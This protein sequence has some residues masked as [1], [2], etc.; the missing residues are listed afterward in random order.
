MHYKPLK[1]AFVCLIGAT[2]ISLAVAVHIQHNV[3]DLLLHEINTNQEQIVQPQSLNERTERTI[4]STS[5]FKSWMPYQAITS[6]I[7]KQYELQ[8]EAFT[9][10]T[11]GLRMIGK[12]YMIAVTSQFG[13]VGDLVEVHTTETSFYAIIG[14]IKDAGHD[15][16][17]SLIDTSIVEFIV[18]NDTLDSDVR[19]L[20]NLN[21]IFSG[22]VIKI[23]NLGGYK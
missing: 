19:R 15:D 8:Q 11:Y 6:K 22:E 5:S 13:S 9:E 14:D 3:I 4:C 2:I 1:I 20:G 12:Y 16:C 17:Q 23:N 21:H 18:D 7:S 10:P